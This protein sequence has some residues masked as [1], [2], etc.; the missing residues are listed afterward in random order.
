MLDLLIGSK[1][2]DRRK[3]EINMPKRW[4]SR[5]RQSHT[6]TERKN[7]TKKDDEMVGFI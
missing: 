4:R 6:D 2:R 7:H 5:N 3:K 1:R